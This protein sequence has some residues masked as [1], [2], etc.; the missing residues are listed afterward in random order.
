MKVGLVKLGRSL[1]ALP[2]RDSDRTSAQDDHAVSPEIL[3]YAVHMH[4][5]ETQRI[6]ELGLR[7]RQVKA[8]L[9][10]KANAFIRT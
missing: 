3:E 9:I 4:G 6:P 2:V 5:R 8:V 10:D 1:E 7:H